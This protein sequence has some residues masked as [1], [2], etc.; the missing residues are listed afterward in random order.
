M[1]EGGCGDSKGRGQ[2]GGE[3]KL[4]D[5]GRRVLSKDSPEKLGFFEER[6][7]VVVEMV[8]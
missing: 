1:G 8:V 7:E 4:A 5:H 3:S 2:G 6:F